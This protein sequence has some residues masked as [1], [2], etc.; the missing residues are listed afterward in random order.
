[1]ALAI[2]FSTDT[3]KVNCYFYWNDMPLKHSLIY[4]HTIKQFLKD[5]STILVIHLIV[6]CRNSQL[7]RGVNLKMAFNTK[8]WVPT[9]FGIACVWEDNNQSTDA[10]IIILI[11]SINFLTAKYLVVTIITLS[12]KSQ[13][14][15]RQRIIKLRWRVIIV[16]WSDQ[17]TSNHRQIQEKSSALTRL[18]NDDH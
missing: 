2:D 3:E 4:R 18:V 12:L 8:L 1:M 10:I 5:S 14:K 6:M 15:R 13:G 17:L 16:T 11:K 9:R 7:P